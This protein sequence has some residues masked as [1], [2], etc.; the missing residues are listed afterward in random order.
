M[1]SNR[2]G[3]LDQLKFQLTSSTIKGP[4]TPKL[5]SNDVQATPVVHEVHKVPP[6]TEGFWCE[7]VPFDSKVVEPF[8]QHQSQKPRR[9]SP[10]VAEVSLELPTKSTFSP[11]KFQVPQV[12]WEQTS[13][14]FSCISYLHT[15]SYEHRERER[16]ENQIDRN[17]MKYPQSLHHWNVKTQN[18]QNTLC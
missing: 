6:K 10:G 12:D 11:Q 8:G 5:F 16:G 18:L 17:I 9:R 15:K 2:L 14:N 3:A 1:A 13:K 4:A 7:P